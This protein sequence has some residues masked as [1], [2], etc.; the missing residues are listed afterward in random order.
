MAAK[1][2]KVRWVAQGKMLSEII[3][4]DEVETVGSVLLF[5]DYDARIVLALPEDR[6]VDAA[7]ADEAEDES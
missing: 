4:L 1:K 6:F 5:R 2:T 3:A 7:P